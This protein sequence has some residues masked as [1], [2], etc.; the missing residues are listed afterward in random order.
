MAVP[1]VGDPLTAV[2]PVPDAEPVRTVD[3][4]VLVVGGGTGGVAAALAA[5]GE[6]RDV[7]LIEETDWLGG[8]FTSQGVSALDEHEHIEDFGGTATYYALRDGVRAHYRTPGL[9]ECEASELNPGACW[10]SKLAFEPRVAA[11]QLDRMLEPLCASG[12]LTVFRRMKVVAVEVHEARVCTATALAFDTTPPELVRFVPRLV[13]DA[14]ELGDLLPLVGTSYQVGAEAVATTGEAHAQPT[15]P[16]PSCVQ[17]FT[18]T[19]AL[20]RCAI[21]E[22]HRMPKPA[23]Y[24]RL[25][26]RQP[27]SLTIEVHG[28][29]I[30]SELGGTLTYKLFETMPGTKGSLWTYRR[31]LGSDALP[32][33]ASNEI[34]M[35]ELARALTIATRPCWT[36]PL[37][38]S[39]PHCKQRNASVL[40]FCT[41]S[42]RRHPPTEIEPVLRNFGCDTT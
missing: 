25:R 27:Y 34:S 33:L 28:G 14:T 26:D 38:W 4:E 36:L 37:R 1:A 6:G 23:G 15:G 13:V 9:S 8:Q 29:E 2:V 31:L 16:A 39:R 24:E 10:V 5:A 40:D 3:C 18:Y 17:G 30:Y 35:I 41:G 12:R 42:R 32:K 22:N 7:C 21:G 19:F 11:D 20:E